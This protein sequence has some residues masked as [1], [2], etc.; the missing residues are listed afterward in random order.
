MNSSDIKVGAKIDNYGER[1]ARLTAVAD[2]QAAEAAGFDSLWMSDHILMPTETECSYPFSDS[3]DLVWNPAAPWF[4]A[5]IWAATL[6][7]V[8][9]RVEIGTATL[10][11]GLRNPLELA[12]QI[13]TIDAVSGGRFI[14][15][16]GAGWMTEEFDALGISPAAR[17]A[18]LDEWIGLMRDAWTGFVEPREGRFYTLDRQVHMVPTPAREVPV[19]FGGMSDA[20]FRRVARHRGGWL[21]LLKPSEDPLEV[22]PAGIAKIRAFAEAAGAP[23]D[24]D[25]RVMYNAADPT[26]VGT[27]LDQLAAVGVSD[28]MV[29]VD[30]D[31]PDGPRRAIAEVRG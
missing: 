7:A 8:T 13:A 27:L 11:P 14:L 30:F 22:I 19:L 1:S 9:E 31:D 20:A 15:G 25:I 12:K 21:P 6:A 3:G 10:I 26:T 29:D 23:Y 2:A 16:A 28:V 17:G 18:R 4:D 5:L 24:G